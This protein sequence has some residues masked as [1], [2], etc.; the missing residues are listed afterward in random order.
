MDDN[1]TNVRLLTGACTP[2]QGRKDSVVTT[3]FN[4]KKLWKEQFYLHRIY[5]IHIMYLYDIYLYIYIYIKR[6][7]WSC[8]D[9][10]QFLSLAS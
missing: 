4:Q 5:Y 10:N 6:T 2:L 9:Q 7:S 3:V 1:D 8:T